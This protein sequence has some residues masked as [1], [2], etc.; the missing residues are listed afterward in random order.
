MSPVPAASPSAAPPSPSG[1]GGSGRPDRSPGSDASTTASG[2]ASGPGSSS[3]A[4]AEAE[5]RRSFWL[6][7]LLIGGVILVGM[8]AMAVFYDPAST[9]PPSD[10]EVVDG[11][12]PDIVPQPN[13][14]RAPDSAFDRGGWG[15]LAVLGLMVVG[16]VGAILVVA[17]GGG[18]KARANRAAWAAAAERDADSEAAPS[19]TGRVPEKGRSSENGPA[20]EGP[21][22]SAEPDSDPG[23]PPP[24]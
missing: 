22:V 13:S 5:E 7:G 19:N 20:A 16:A 14:G 3:R 11:R 9:P 15:Q 1:S 6:A 21:A 12:A 24:S 8:L 4:A 17:R 23:A 2:P 18:S 10:T